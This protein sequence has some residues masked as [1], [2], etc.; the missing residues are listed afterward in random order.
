MTPHDVNPVGIV[1]LM[2]IGMVAAIA[3]ILL[4]KNAITVREAAG[5]ILW[6][7]ILSLAA[8][9]TPLLFPSASTF[10]LCGVAAALAVAG[11][12]IVIAIMRKRFGVADEPI[13]QQGQ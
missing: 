1:I 11:D 6:G 4:A 12:S 3:K 13:E 2:M 5:R 7:G 10:M 9:A 8:S